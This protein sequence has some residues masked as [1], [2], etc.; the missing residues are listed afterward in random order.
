MKNKITIDEQIEQRWQYCHIEE[1]GGI[2]NGRNQA[3]TC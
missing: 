1:I 3:K 2:L